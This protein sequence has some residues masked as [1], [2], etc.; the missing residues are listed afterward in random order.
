[1]SAPDWTEIFKKN[2]M[3]N[4]PGYNETVEEIKKKMKSVPDK[5]KATKNKK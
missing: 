2:P 4:P 5:H 1:M 3:L